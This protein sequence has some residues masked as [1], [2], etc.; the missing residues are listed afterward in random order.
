V[1]LKVDCLDSLCGN[2]KS[3][4]VGNREIGEAELWELFSFFC[5]YVVMFICHEVNIMLE[6]RSKTLELTGRSPLTL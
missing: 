6:T 2:R 5:V 4:V 1:W 3:G